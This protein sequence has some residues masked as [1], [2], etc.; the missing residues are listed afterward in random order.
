M[1][2]D[3]RAMPTLP[4]QH[5]V[6]AAEKVGAILAKAMNFNGTRNNDHLRGTE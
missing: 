2:E 1:G 4:M 6:A 5:L 3:Q